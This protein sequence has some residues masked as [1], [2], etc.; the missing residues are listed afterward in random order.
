MSA[1]VRADGDLRIGK[2]LNLFCVLVTVGAFVFVERHGFFLCFSLIVMR[3][4]P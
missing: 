3:D 4:E 2:L 1:A